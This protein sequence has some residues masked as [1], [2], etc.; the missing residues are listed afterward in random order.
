MVAED[1]GKQM[2]VMT[3]C[4]ENYFEFLYPQVVNISVTQSKYINFFLLY[5]RI[6]QKKII[7]LIEFCKNLDNL[8]LYPI[9]IDKN[10]NIYNK[11]AENGGL[12]STSK[13]FFPYEVYF[14]LN[15]YEFLPLWVDRILAIHAGDIMMLDDI[16]NFYD[17]EFNDC[18]VTLELTNYYI[19]DER[20]KDNKDLYSIE[21]REFFIEN[22]QGKT[23]FF[24]S[25][26]MLL[27]ID[28][29][30][31]NDRG[32][33]YYLDVL[34]TMKKLIKSKKNSSL[35][36]GDQAFYSIAYLGEIN[37]FNG[38]SETKK[39]HRRY[40]YSIYS[41]KKDMS[42]GFQGEKEIKIFHF[43]GKFKPWLFDVN[44]LNSIS[45]YKFKEKLGKKPHKFAP[46][47]FLAYFMKFWE[48]E[49]QSPFY[50]KH[51][52][53]AAIRAKIWQDF[54]LPLLGE[55]YRN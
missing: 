18:L 45:S 12:T 29:Q 14:Q 15:A 9:K 55:Q 42:Y 21:D 24:N 43:D 28:K 33:D 4:D 16:S 49:K 40:N 25:G 8:T 23:A 7:G 3:S 54:Y 17:S 47:I 19:S 6:E 37:I 35:F 10:I 2:N 38:I 50:E 31:E 11:F 48:Y 36:V 53:E 22:H 51:S 34:T 39:N 26:V 52:Y 5:N 13:K 1:K 27:N 41:Y 44:T 30:R 32:L 46:A 20:T